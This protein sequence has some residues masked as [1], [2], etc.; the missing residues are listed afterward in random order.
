MASSHQI[1]ENYNCF[2]EKSISFKEKIQLELWASSQIWG[3]NNTNWKKKKNGKIHLVNNQYILSYNSTFGAHQNELDIGET[4]GHLGKNQPEFL[5]VWVFSWLRSGILGSIFAKRMS[6]IF[7][8][9]SLDI[10]QTQ[11]SKWTCC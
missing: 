5:E 2:K 10:F 3:V 7:S 4:E 9:T 6:L 1:L 8:I 11:Y